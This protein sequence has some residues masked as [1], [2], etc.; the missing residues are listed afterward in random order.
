MGECNKHNAAHE[1]FI[2][3]SINDTLKKKTTVR[4]HPVWL[5]LKSDHTKCW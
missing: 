2:R 4:G 5:K 1:T 3:L